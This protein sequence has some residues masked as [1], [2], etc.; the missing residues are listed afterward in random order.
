V[1]DGDAMTVLMV[2]DEE[3]LRVPVATLLRRRGFVVLEADD[4]GPAI[5][6]YRAAAAEID[7]V[8]LDMTL[9]SMPGVDVL[10]ELERICPDA[11]VV[12]TSAYDQA[13]VT[14]TLRGGRPW[15][16]IQKPYSSTALAEL[17]RTAC[18]PRHA[19]TA[20]AL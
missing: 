5:D 14:H 18:P 11:K 19:E 2:E 7:V 10:A 3:R 4:G 20:A 17:L 8:L 1:L 6:L 13:T 16:Y 12:L 15:A 9:P